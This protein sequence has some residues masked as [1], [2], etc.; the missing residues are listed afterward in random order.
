MSGTYIDANI[1]VYAFH[2]QDH[3]H[4][5]RSRELLLEVLRGGPAIT[6]ALTIDEVVWTLRKGIGRHHAI[7]AARK[8]LKTP[9]LVIAAV[10]RSHVEQSLEL[11][12]R[13]GLDPRDAIHAAVAIHDGCTQIL[14]DDPDFDAVEDLE[15]ISL[16]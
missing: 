12:D 11:A 10:H 9:R 3:P 13:T 7:E 8:V 15:R 4:Q 2:P 1:L 16:A 6:C 5:A 14:S